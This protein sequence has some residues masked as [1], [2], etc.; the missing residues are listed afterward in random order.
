MTLFMAVCDVEAGSD[1]LAYELLLENLERTESVMPL[2]IGQIFETADLEI[3]IQAKDVES[4]NDFILKRIRSIKEIRE[5]MVYPIT[6]FKGL[7]QFSLADFQSSYSDQDTAVEFPL[8]T[9]K[10]DI[11]P[12][13][14]IE[15][16]QELSKITMSDTVLPAFLGY[17]FQQADFDIGF[18]FFA[19][20]IQ[21]SWDFIMRLREIDGIWDTDIRVVT[22]IKSLVSA[23]DM[24]HVMS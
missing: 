11:E 21:S 4:L 2:F 20:D 17:T 10:L 1:K 3:M 5:I 13:K 14:D 15:V 16:Y 18:Y 19:M 23:K 7:A 9:V 24:S 8:F 22:R 12:T 6:S